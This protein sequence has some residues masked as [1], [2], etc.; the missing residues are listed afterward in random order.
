MPDSV[1]IICSQGA[2]ANLPPEVAIVVLALDALVTE[3]NKDEPFGENNEITKA[4]RT[5]QNDLINGTS[6]SNDIG[7]ALNTMWND[8]V[9]GIGPNNDILRLINSINI[10][11]E[12]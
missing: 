11:I 5:V 7:S 12:I 2:C 4:I 3:L 10:H 8:I 9:N 6:S 1:S